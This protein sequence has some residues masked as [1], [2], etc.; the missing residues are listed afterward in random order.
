[1]AILIPLGIITLAGI[2]YMAV[3]RK[4]SFTLRLVALGALAL[5][6]VT[7]I[8]C[9]LFIFGVIETA[10]EPV[11]SM[12]DA[13]PPPEPTSENSNPGPLILLIIFLLAM[14]GGIIFLS[15]REQKRSKNMKE[16]NPHPDGSRW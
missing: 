7:I 9:L 11:Q 1:M 8:I 10:V 12:P 13:P 16:V 2:I 14:F 5:M 15:L 3:S 6:V 4:S